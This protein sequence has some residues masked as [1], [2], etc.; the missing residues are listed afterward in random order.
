MRRPS[1]IISNRKGGGWHGTN[2]FQWQCAYP[3]PRPCTSPTVPA[4]AI[5]RLFPLTDE[6]EVAPALPHTMLDSP[7]GPP[8]VQ[9]YRPQYLLPK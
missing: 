8:L 2:S 4:C 1:D 9:L 6:A 5:A 3:S 7:L